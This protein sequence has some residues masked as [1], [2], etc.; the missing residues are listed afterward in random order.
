MFDFHELRRTFGITDVKVDVY[1][2]SMIV[3]MCHVTLYIG[4]RLEKCTRSALIMVGV[5]S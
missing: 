2:M 5:G 3:E 1:V 4:W